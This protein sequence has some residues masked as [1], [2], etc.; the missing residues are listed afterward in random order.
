MKLQF[1]RK[2]NLSKVF[3]FLVF[4]LLFQNSWGQIIVSYTGMGAVTCPAAP[5]ATISP[6]VTGLTFS[7]LSRGIGVTCASAT[8]GISGSVFNGTLAANISANDWYTFS[9][10]SDATVSFTVSAL[11]I[12]SQISNITGSPNVS[13][14]YS[15][16]AGAK[17]VIGSFTPTTTSTAY[18]FT[19]GT[20]ISVGASQTINIYVIPNTLTASTT[21]AR[22]NNATSITVTTTPISSNTITTSAIAGSPFCA[23]TSVSVPFT[24]SGTFTAGNVFTAQ[25]SSSTGSFASP[26]TLGT[27][28]QTTAGTITGTIP[29]GTA[30]GTLYRIRVIGSTPSTTGTDNGA[31]ITINTDAPASI[32][33]AASPSN[34]I[35]TGTSVTFTATPTNG[36]AGPSYQWKKNG[37]NVGANSTTYID[38][39][40]IN[41]DAITCIITSNAACVTGSPA[42]SNVITMTVS[43]PVTPSLTIAASA[44]PICAGTNVTF[45]PT[46]TNGGTP[47]YQWKK[48]GGNV[49]TGATYSDAALVNG[50][51]ITCVMTATGCVSPATATSNTIT[52]TVNALPATPAAG[53]NSAICSSATL[54]LTSNATGTIAW[55]GPNTFTSA[56]QNPS[57]VG[58][59]TAATGTYSVTSTVGGCTSIAGTTAV[60]VNSG[61]AITVQPSSTSTSAGANATFAVTATG[62][63]LTYQW[64]ESING[65]GSFSTITNGGV[66]SGA[67][68][69]TLTLT[70][71][72]L[73]M[74]TYKYRC[75][76]TGTC[77][78]ATSNGAATLTVTTVVYAAGDY[79]TNPAFSTTNPSSIIFLNSTVSVTGVAPWQQYN[80][81]AWV[82]VVHATGSPNSPM[83]L[84]T[85][86]PTIYI[87]HGDYANGVYVDGA[88]TGTYNNIIVL[89]GGYFKILASTGITI[90]TTKT[91]EIQSGGYAEV[92]G[93][94]ASAWTMTSGSNLKVKTGG[95]LIFNNS[96][97]LNTNPIWGGTEDFEDNSTVEIQNWSYASSVTTRS[98]LNPTFQVNVNSS[99]NGYRFGN[100]TYNCTPSQDQT[101]L[102]GLTGTALSFCNNLTF[103]NKSTTSTYSIT[104]NQIG[105]PVQPVIGG[106]VT[107]SEGQVNIGTNFTNGATQLVTIL[108]NLNIQ[109]NNPANPGLLYLHKFGTGGTTLAQMDLYLGG[110]LLVASGATLSTAPDANGRTNSTLNFM[111]G[112]AQIVSGAGTI[113]LSNITINK[114][115]NDVTLQRNLQAD[116]KL[117]F[118]AHDFILGT[119]TLTLGTASAIGTQVG[120]S[121]SSYV[122][123][124]NNGVYKRMQ[125]A[126]STAYPFPVGPSL[127]SYNPATINYT[128]TVDDFSARVEV[129]LNPTTGNDPFFVNRTWNIAE[130]V[131]GG[132][133]ATLTLQWENTPTTHENVSFVRTNSDIYHYTGGAW[134]EQTGSTLGG[135]DPYT[136]SVGGLTSFSPFSVGKKAV[137]PIELLSFTANYNGKTVDLKWATASEL[138]NDYFT[139]ERSADAV[140]FELIN[141]TDGAGNSTQTLFYSTV[142]DAPLNGISYYRLKQTD[143]DGNFSYSNIVSV[144][145]EKNNGFQ[146][147]YTFNS[148]EN[149]ILNVTVN[150]GNNC[151]LNFELY[152]MTGKKVFSSNENI[153]GSNRNVSIPS[154]N[155]SNGIYLLKVYNGE[156]MISKKLKL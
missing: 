138:N 109:N 50:D 108:G 83:N 155:L 145:I 33:I 114:T 110:D 143:F 133:T 8:T 63:G 69:A 148:I 77:G 150:C 105:S 19:P 125:L 27:L 147:L 72:T 118:T 107:V 20:A 25:L 4:V 56:I 102:P 67:T 111:F 97:M 75:V 128:G 90:A 52:M 98:L 142:D 94:G 53:S 149:G 99:G 87:T 40:L 24:I 91:F 5:T 45:T 103:I 100:V 38:A 120:G 82:D 39:G 17:T 57:I 36:G 126:N 104:A 32:S 68:T 28:T 122:V 47:S 140:N 76:V 21:T 141:S 13:V 31:D 86:P 88:G 96:A 134:V 37:I 42:T 29:T 80:G 84:A 152:D 23:N 78:N 92:A 119:N 139:I 93:T 48:N 117:T 6:A 74:D 127:T 46:P 151:L 7:Q 132:T 89:S 136:S 130:T 54:N 34:N 71:V 64:E 26:V 35:C 70:G 41:T 112:N 65:G 124:D 44:N 11:S 18:P 153:S 9:V 51:L 101:V 123:T 49:G 137:L 129:G 55:T 144:D 2:K 22:V 1:L 85:K 59:T 113:S 30:T 66:Y 79:R 12:V 121:S 3:S 14:Q 106:N 60:T 116:E 154:K 62:A 58:A 146:I 131:A 156:K 135:A 73:A 95:T 15:I 43:T 61:A 115:A 10:T 16:G 81:S